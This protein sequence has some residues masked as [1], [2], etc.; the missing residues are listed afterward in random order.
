MELT[1]DW[2]EDVGGGDAGGGGDA[3]AGDDVA[4]GGR[5]RRDPSLPTLTPEQALADLGTCTDEC[6]EPHRP[7]A[8]CSAKP[9]LDTI[10]QWV[11]ATAGPDTVLEWME[12]VP[13]SGAAGAVP[14]AEATAA[15]APPLLP[16][17]PTVEA[18]GVRAAAAVLGCESESCILAHPRFRRWG[19]AHGVPAAAV[20]QELAANFKAPGPRTGRRWLSNINIDR[21]LERWARVFPDFFPC[22]FA[23]MDF[24]RTQEPFATIALSDVLDGRIPTN[25]GTGHTRRRNRCF[26]TAVN[27]DVSTGPGEHWVAVF[28]DCRGPRWTVEYFNSTGNPPPRPM[29]GW[30]ERTRQHLAGHPRAPAGGVEAVA[31]TDV[32]H[33]ESNTECGLYAMYYIRRRLE[34]TPH[35][36]FRRQVIPDAAMVAFRQHCFRHQ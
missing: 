24:D 11:E 28:V 10:Q 33:Q 1:A 14:L 31:V 5:R 19:E 12:V 32:N 35:E 2:F 21:T 23:M 22:G 18:A 29:V 9:M 4:G 30:M 36:F 34:E 3:V 20:E 27:T 16:T 15:E 13:V 25:I 7:G 26:A 6:A 17:D 8:P